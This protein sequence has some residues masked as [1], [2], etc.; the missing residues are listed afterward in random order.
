MAKPANGLV[1][2]IGADT[3][4]QLDCAGLGTPYTDNAAAHS[5]LDRIK[6]FQEVLPAESDS[7]AAL[8]TL[9]AAVVNEPKQLNPSIPSPPSSMLSGLY[10]F[11]EFVDAD[12]V[13]K[14]KMQNTATGETFIMPKPK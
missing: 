8:K 5:I 11:M 2:S 9:S 7:S 10:D 3:S 6:G 4:K 1:V 12:G 14:F 13:T